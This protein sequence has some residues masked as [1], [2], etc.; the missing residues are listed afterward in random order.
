MLADWNDHRTMG[1][2]SIAAGFAEK[3]VF[4][5]LTDP[6]FAL[7]LD[8]RVS[9]LRAALRPR[10]Y[11]NLA[12]ASDGGDTKAGEVLLKACGDIT[13]GTNVVTNVTQTNDRNEDFADRLKDRFREREVAA[14]QDRFVPTDE[15]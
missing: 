14:R 12:K 15:D 2:K 13:G 7:E 6:D 1:E 11:A 10:V 5:L 4:Q 3:Y 8:K 9:Q